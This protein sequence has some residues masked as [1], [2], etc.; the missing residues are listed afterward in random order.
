LAWR[1]FSNRLPTKDN[2]VHRGIL[3]GNDSACGEGCD[4]IENV[5][6]LFLQY[7]F[8]GE[9]WSH[10]FNWL[11]ISFVFT[12][13]LRQHF[14]HFTKMAGMLLFSHLFFRIIWFVIVWVIWKERN[15]RIFQHTMSTPFTLIE[16][17]KLNSFLW[18]KFK[19]VVLAFTRTDG[20]APFFIWVFFC[21][22]LL[23]LLAGAVIVAP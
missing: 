4:S 5:V 8:S 3:H 12:D 6:H 16:K 23:L 19:K 14:T 18:L 2:L 22:F 15:N 7:K 11:G 9:L 20:D 17:V 1:I 10:V 21:N 13:E